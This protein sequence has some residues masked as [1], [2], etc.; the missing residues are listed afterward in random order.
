MAEQTER[1]PGACPRCGSKGPHAVVGSTPSGALL[2]CTAKADD[3]PGRTVCA[4][5]W[6]EKTPEDVAAAAERRAAVEAAGAER[7]AH[8]R[9]VVAS[10]PVERI[11]HADMAA[12]FT[13]AAQNSDGTVESVLRWLRG[14]GYELTRSERVRCSCLDDGTRSPVCRLHGDADAIEAL[15]ARE[16]PEC[17]CPDDRE[18]LEE[19]CPWCMDISGSSV[20]TSCP[21]SGLGQF[22]EGGEWQHLDGTDLDVRLHADYAVSLS[23]RMTRGAE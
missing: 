22:I 20:A 3:I 18:C 12:A 10:G 14:N 13:Q 6:I 5:E 15:E 21:A 4:E 7:V 2:H 23:Y 8:I 19:T 9:T 1:A 16:V 17:V 11:T